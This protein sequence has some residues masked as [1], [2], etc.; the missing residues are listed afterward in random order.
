MN[1]VKLVL[2]TSALCATFPNLSM[3]RS[4][5]KAIGALSVIALTV[6]L[7]PTVTAQ[8]VPPT[9]QIIDNASATGFTKT[10]TW[11]TVSDSASY[12]GKYLYTTTSNASTTKAVWTFTNL[13]PG[14]YKVSVTYRPKS[15][16]STKAEF[17][18]FDG[19]VAGKD[20]GVTTVNETSR[21]SSGDIDGT[22]WQTLGTPGGHFA[23]LM[24]SL[25]VTLSANASASVQ[26]DAV[27]IE[28][29]GNLT[30]DEMLRD[31][32][33]AGTTIQST[34]DG[35]GEEETVSTI[36]VLVLYTSDAP[37]AL[38]LTDAELERLI[39]R[40]FDC[41]ITTDST[42][43]VR[44]GVPLNV[45]GIMKASGVPVNFRIVELKKI[46]VR[47]IDSTTDM[48]Y[49]MQTNENVESLRRFT[50]ADIVVTFAP[51]TSSSEVVGLTYVPK[52]SVP[53]PLDTI[54]ESA[55]KYIYGSHIR[56]SHFSAFSIVRILSNDS[57]FSTLPMTLTHE[58][59]HILAA[60]HEV[61]N[62]EVAV[63]PWS[64]AYT[65]DGGIK[66]I[67]AAYGGNGYTYG[68]PTLGCVLVPVFSNPQKTTTIGG[69]TY[70]LGIADKSD[71]VRT[72]KKLAPL[73]AGYSERGA[74]SLYNSEVCL[75][76]TA[77]SI[78]SAIDS[79]RVINYINEDD[80]VQEIQLITNLR[81]IFFE[82]GFIDNNNDGWIS[83]I[84]ALRI[85][86][87]IN[88]PTN[89]AFAPANVCPH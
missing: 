78:V 85:I 82:Y 21:A 75:D 23:V 53:V 56:N 8:S 81:K 16:F 13:S 74:I 54:I 40:N 60:G 10:G 31:F 51:V 83:P 48:L 67:D 77:D 30:G 58:I 22:P 37:S 11:Y 3:V 41:D 26:A 64:H 47:S 18:V 2:H 88:D 38:H 68:C 65:V 62:T 29:I 27:R 79:L 42:C 35:E 34:I 4:L 43:L 80:P 72:M 9:V 61:E 7:L 66:T 71:N 89:P 32:A 87:H 59:G 84:D 57:E 70:Q 14:Q 63:E 28:R 36:D 52:Y 20:L 15:Y 55:D 46:T 45:N 19:G 86:N 25:S 50:N 76:S 44:S 69:K 12:A 24:N 6:S 17:R 33:S 1:E 39:R 49:T 73:V 5:K